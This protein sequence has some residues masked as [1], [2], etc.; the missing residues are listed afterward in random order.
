MFSKSSFLIQYLLLFIYS[1][2]LLTWWYSWLHSFGGQIDIYIGVNL[3]HHL[4]CAS[5]SC[6]WILNTAL[7]Y[8]LSKIVGQYGCF[9]PVVSITMTDRYD[10]LLITNKSISVFNYRLEY[11]VDAVNGVISLKGRLRQINIGWPKHL[12]EVPVSSQVCV[13]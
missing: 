6:P 10:M 7:S 5:G 12:I 3:Y 1:F 4:I 9:F 2:I 8:S 13:C 11:I